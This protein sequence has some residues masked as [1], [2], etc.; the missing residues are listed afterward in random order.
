MEVETYLIGQCYP[1]NAD[2]AFNDREAKLE[3]DPED[4][5]STSS[6]LLVSGLHLENFQ[7]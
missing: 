7:L 6:R 5:D 2:S 4:I 1:L 3:S